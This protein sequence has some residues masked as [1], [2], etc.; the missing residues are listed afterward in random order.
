MS[1]RWRNHL[2]Y[3]PTIPAEG[4]GAHPSDVCPWRIDGLDDFE[5]L[6]LSATLASMRTTPH[7]E[8]DSHE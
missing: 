5:F 4:G 2:V 3:T 6:A 7:K 8:A 1:Y